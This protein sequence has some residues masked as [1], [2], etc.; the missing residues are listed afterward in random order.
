MRWLGL[1]VLSVRVWLLAIL[2]LLGL[3]YAGTAIVGDFLVQVGVYG[4]R[5]YE[6]KDFQRQELLEGKA[7]AR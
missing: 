7:P 5:V 2:T 4:P 1:P 6:P 3:L